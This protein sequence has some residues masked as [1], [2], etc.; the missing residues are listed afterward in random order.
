MTRANQDKLWIPCDSTL[1]DT[2]IIIFSFNVLKS[3]GTSTDK[4]LYSTL[5]KSNMRLVNIHIFE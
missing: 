2:Q 1:S 4:C 3:P 5:N